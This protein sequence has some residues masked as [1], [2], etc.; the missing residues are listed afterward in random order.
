MGHLHVV[1]VEVVR[2]MERD[3][4]YNTRA[5]AAAQWCGVAEN[6]SADALSLE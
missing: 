1:P 5:A 4:H 6:R 3:S 2:I